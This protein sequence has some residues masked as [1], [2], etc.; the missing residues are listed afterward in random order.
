MLAQHE[1]AVHDATEAL[2]WLNDE[3]DVWLIRACSYMALGEEEAAL[4][5]A[6]C[7]T[8]TR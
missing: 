4:A 1:D 2:H 8:A 7:A 5:F 6:A 3:P